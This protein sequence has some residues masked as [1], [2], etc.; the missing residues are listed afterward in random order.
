[1]C[2]PCWSPQTPRPLV[3][4]VRPIRPFLCGP[5]SPVWSRSSRSSSPISLNLVPSV[6]WGTVDPY[7]TLGKARGQWENQRKT[8]GKSEENGG[9]RRFYG[10]NP[11]VMSKWLMKIAI[12]TDTFVIYTD[13]LIL[14][15]LVI[16]PLKKHCSECNNL[17]CSYWNYLPTYPLVM[18]NIAIEH[19][20]WNRVFSQ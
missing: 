6:P 13:M 10:I 3:L 17:Y 8:R 14:E 5:T 12:Y 18:T 9:F 4:S 15:I 16:Y 2:V 1:M 19:G 20:H 7:K 11:L